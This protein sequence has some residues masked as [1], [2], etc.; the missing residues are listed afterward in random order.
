MKK[1]EDKNYQIIGHP[2]LVRLNPN[3][4]WKTRGNGAVSINLENGDPKKIKEIIEEFI[5]KYARFDDKKTNPGFVILKGQP[6]FD[7]Y[8]KSVK[9]IVTLEETE[10]LLDSLGAVYKGYKNKRGLIG[11]TASIAWSP[12][13]DKTYE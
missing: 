4:P 5:D 12:K 9:G 10:Q 7:I 8:E 1:L 11:A 3:I 6:S 2:R 13:H